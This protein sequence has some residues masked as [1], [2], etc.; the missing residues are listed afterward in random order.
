MVMLVLRGSSFQSR[1]ARNGVDAAL[2]VDVTIAKLV[3]LISQEERD[4][5]HEG[6]AY[7]ARRTCSSCTTQRLCLRA[8]ARETFRNNVADEAEATCEQLLA[9]YV[10]VPTWQIWDGNVSGLCF[11]A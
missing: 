11:S 3:M 4:G 7:S 1:R 2:P 8:K 6:S 10:N 9:D 5:I